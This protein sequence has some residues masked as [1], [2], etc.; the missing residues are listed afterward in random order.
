V[1]EKGAIVESGRHAELLARAGRY[2]HFYRLRFSRESAAG[3]D[4][5]SIVPG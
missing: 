1:V 2:A 3:I 4:E 5:V